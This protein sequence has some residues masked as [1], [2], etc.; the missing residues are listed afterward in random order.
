MRK[1]LFLLLSCSL[2]A[3]YGFAQTF[4]P[5]SDDVPGVYVYSIEDGNSFSGANIMLGDNF[6]VWPWS[7]GWDKAFTPEKGGTYTMKFTFQTTGSFGG[8]RV[9]WITDNNYGIDKG[10]PFT[11]GMFGEGEGGPNRFTALN[12]N[13][14]VADGVSCYFTGGPAYGIDE[15]YTHIVNFTMDDVAAGENIGSLGI[16]G[17]AGANAFIVNTIVIT[18]SKGNM[19]VNYARNPA[20]QYFNITA[21]AGTGGSISPNGAITVDSGDNQ[22]FTFAPNSGYKINRVLIDGVNNPTA[23]S[24]G[25]YTFTNVTKNHTI[26]V[27]FISDSLIETGW[28]FGFEPSEMGEGMEPWIILNSNG[29]TFEIT[30]DAKTGS[31]AMKVDVTET[32]DRIWKAQIQAP[33]FKV[34]PGH[35]YKLSFWA[36]M[37]GDSPSW[38]RVAS[39]DTPLNT[40]GEDVSASG[41]QLGYYD[42]PPR[43]S[44]YWP[45][46]ND[47]T[48]TW[49]EFVYDNLVPNQ[50]EDFDGVVTLNFNFGTP[51]DEAGMYYN[52]DVIEAAHRIYFIDDITLIDLETTPPEPEKFTI[53]AM[54]GG[55]AHGSISPSG[56]ITVNRGDNQTFTFTPDVGHKIYRVRID[57]VNNLTAVLQ[58]SYTF[59]NV[60]ANHTIDIAFVSDTPLTDWP[61]GFEPSEM[62][63]GMEPCTIL[64]SDGATFE[65]TSDAYMGNGA[66]KVNVSETADMAWKAQF[67]IPFFNVT[68]G[69]KY[70]FSFWAKMTGTEQ[71]WLRVSSEDTPL[72]NFGNDLSTSGAQLGPDCYLPDCRD[73][74]GLPEIYWPFI[75]NISDTWQKFVYDDIITNQ[76][77][78]FNG[79]VTLS[80]NF[81]TPINED[82]K[83]YMPEP[84]IQGARTYFLDNIM[85][86]DLNATPPEP[87]NVYL[88]VTTNN[89]DLG[90]VL[91]EGSYTRNSQVTIYAIPNINVVFTGWTDG[92]TDNPRKI[93]VSENSTFTANFE[94]RNV[95][96]LLSQIAGLETD[97]VIYRAQIIELKT[98]IVALETFISNLQGL[99]DAASN[100]ILDLQ[101]Q[102]DELENQLKECKEGNSAP[103]LKV[104]SLQLYPN[105]ATDH[106]TISGLKG[107]E[108]LR[109]YDINGIL[110]FSKE[111]MQETE[112][113]SINHLPAGIYLVRIGNSAIRVMKK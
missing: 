56:T 112:N 65:I 16:R 80:F 1:N 60:I 32:A 110:L 59:T 30:N 25:S 28:S 33:T 95:T 44:G 47:I 4:I 49:Q 93:I 74:D 46:I 109:F 7:A 24:Q 41:A 100:T 79:V 17:G 34:I 37:I 42:G 86:V 69:H 105:P 8:M 76:E 15:E 23:V 27:S 13:N 85:L 11:V 29:A 14:A 96:E 113:I 87:E 39:E 48:N 88:T 3:V 84:V 50:D 45:Y 111:A 78:N 67:V 61:F 92:N 38:V 91:G 108:I 5:P 12:E 40:M 18:D 99:L 9:R 82:G 81:G 98:D 54:V 55:D 64:N 20:S 97:T 106:I 22:T 53:T 101:E 68:P 70:R 83:E 107:N 72:D 75:T 89:N 90:T 103:P 10:E 58:G 102:L 57:G 26:A 43:P 31:G 71:S 63:E 52:P 94:G 2:M 73:A 62:R 66:L 35:T 21:T 104:E 6:N 77:G 36:K 19:L 51:V